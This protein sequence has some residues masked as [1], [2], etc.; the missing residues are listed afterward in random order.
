MYKR[1]EGVNTL[2]LV[3]QKADELDV[4]MP[5]ATGLY[6]ILFEDCSVSEVIMQLMQNPHQD[7]V[8]F[9]TASH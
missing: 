5:L 2:K 4:Y 3:K 9:I 8:E 7:D 6:K 1:Q